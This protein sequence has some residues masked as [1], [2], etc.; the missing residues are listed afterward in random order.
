MKTKFSLKLQSTLIK[1]LSVVFV[2]C[3][4]AVASFAFLGKTEQAS[5]ATAIKP[6]ALYTF[7]DS[8]NL[9]KDTSGNGLHLTSK[10]EV[11]SGV[12]GS[13]T[14]LKLAGKG[15]LH[16]PGL[17]GIKD[18]SDYMTGSYTVR[19]IIKSS[20]KGGAQYLLTTGQ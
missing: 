4:M 20:T 11:S 17:S 19:M 15:G 3:L 18:F 8:A 12:D 7:E 16:A 9:G 6:F 13:D 5:A 2:L 1:V 14:Y 10:G